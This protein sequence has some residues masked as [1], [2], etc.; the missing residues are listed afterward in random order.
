MSHD[1]AFLDNVVTQVIAFEGAGV[2]REY[3]GGYSDWQRQRSAPKEATAPQAEKAA[4]GTSRPRPGATAKLS[5]KETRELEA[6]PTRIGAL[7]EEQAAL[8]AAL[9]DPA[10]YR[11][12]PDR[13]QML[14][15]RYGAVEKELMECLARWEA[16][17]ARPR[18]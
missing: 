2:L 6:M 4:A 16:L 9:A 11:D 12:E 3:I 10:L 7:E 17:E 18:S 15:E 13:V 8:S 1:R 5:Y 14:R